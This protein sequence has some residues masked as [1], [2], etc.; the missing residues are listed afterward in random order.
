MGFLRLYESQGT[1]GEIRVSTANGLHQTTVGNTNIT[2]HPNI[3]GGGQPY[4]VCDAGLQQVVMQRPLTVEGRVEVNDN[5]L[6]AG[7]VST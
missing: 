5:M 6:I 4:I 7:Q 3:D 1:V 2:L